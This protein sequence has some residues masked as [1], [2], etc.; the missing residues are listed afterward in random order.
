MYKENYFFFNS[1]RIS[2]NRTSVDDGPAG[3]SSGFFATLFAILINQNNINAITKKLITE[4]RK[5]PYVTPFQ[6]RS[7]M[8]SAPAAFKAGVN[9]SG[10]IT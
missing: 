8:F 10:V 6:A 2:A 7:L 5:F 4:D 9:K 3:A 1:S